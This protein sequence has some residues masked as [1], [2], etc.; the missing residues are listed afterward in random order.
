[1]HGTENSIY[2]HNNMVIGLSKVVGV[3]STFFPD[4]DDVNL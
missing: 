2:I 1:M 3:M 4:F